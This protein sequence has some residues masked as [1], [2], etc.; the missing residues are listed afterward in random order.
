MAMLLMLGHDLHSND[1]PTADTGGLLQDQA[2]TVYAYPNVATLLNGESAGGAKAGLPR[3]SA[4][5][6]TECPASK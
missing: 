6:V 2:P 3:A 4:K 1:G 5:P